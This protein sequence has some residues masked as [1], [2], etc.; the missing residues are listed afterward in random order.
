[1]IRSGLSTFVF[2]EPSWIKIIFTPAR[3]CSCLIVSPPL[4]MT[5]PAFPAGIMISCTVPFWP[6][7]A[8]SWNCPGGPP[9]PRDTMSSSI[10]FAFCTDSGAPVKDTLRSGRPPLSGEIC[11][12]QP[13]SCWILLICSPPLPMISPTMP[14]GTLYSSVIEV[15][16]GGWMGPS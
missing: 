16:G 9:R 5:K 7:L 15:L 6:P 1:M 4:P 14:S 2:W 3:S 13:E 10:I 11:T 8:L 12:L